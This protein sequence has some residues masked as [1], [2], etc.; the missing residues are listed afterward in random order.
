MNENSYKKRLQFQSNM[1][2]RQSEQI[3]SLKT[4]IEKLE[5]ELLKK[6]EIINSVSSMREELIQNVAEVKKCKKQYKSL[7]EEVRKMK[8]ILNQTIYKGR[9]RLIKFLIK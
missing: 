2:S 1:I 5:L 9:W 8:E 7:I 6:D 3:D 4:K